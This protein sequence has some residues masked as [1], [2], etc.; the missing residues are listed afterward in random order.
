VHEHILAAIVTDDE[1]EAL[2]GIE[3]FDDALAFANDL[4]R[5][6]AASAAAA[7]SAAASAAAAEATA[8]AT[9]AEAATAAAISTAAATAATAA[10]AATVTKAAAAEA[11]AFTWT[12]VKAREFLTTTETVALVTAATTAVTLTPS[13]ETH[14]IQTLLCPEIKKTNALGPWRNRPSAQ[15]HLHARRDLYRKNGSCPSHSMV[16]AGNSAGNATREKPTA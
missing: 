3:E 4:G 8:A 15:N 9:A 2:L 7:E 10:E 5:H 14:V 12:A 6:P 13:I 11:A 16:K 1:A